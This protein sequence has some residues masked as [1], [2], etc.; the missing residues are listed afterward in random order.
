MPNAAI[1][2]NVVRLTLSTSTRQG[3][4]SLDMSL[5]RH[6]YSHCQAG[7]ALGMNSLLYSS[8]TNSNVI[9]D[10]LEVGRQMERLLNYNCSPKVLFGKQLR[11]PSARVYLVDNTALNPNGFPN[12]F[13]PTGGT[14]VWS[15]MIQS[16]YV[17]ASAIKRVADAIEAQPVKSRSQFLNGQQLHAIQGQ[18]GIS[19][20]VIAAFT[21]ARTALNLVPLADR[22]LGLVSGRPDIVALARSF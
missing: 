16:E 7:G 8:V 4:L 18:A 22:N 21:A 3:T 9:D 1:V 20:P 10:V 12:H 5:Q 19:N 15:Q 14:S 11:C 17:A 2:G 6:H 13:F